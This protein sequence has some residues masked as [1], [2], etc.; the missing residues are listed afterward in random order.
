MPITTAFTITAA[1]AVVLL[2][3]LMALI[4][5]RARD[6]IVGKRNGRGKQAA[7]F[8][9]R[10]VVVRWLASLLLLIAGLGIFLHHRDWGYLIAVLPLLFVIATAL[11]LWFL[12][13]D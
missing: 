10:V 13:R 6:Y 7:G 9:I 12:S 4:T 11:D 2:M 3:A 5:Y 8:L 1:L